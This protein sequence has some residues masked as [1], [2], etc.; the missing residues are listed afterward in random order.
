MDPPGLDVSSPPPPK[1]D[2]ASRGTWATA[3]REFAPLAAAGGCIVISAAVLRLTETTAPLTY[4][5]L[6][7]AGLAAYAAARVISAKN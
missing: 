7:I 2:R 1:D 6:V 5:I 3:I 4:G